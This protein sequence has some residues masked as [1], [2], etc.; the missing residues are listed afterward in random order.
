M[1]PTLLKMTRESFPMSRA[2]LT[3]RLK[4]GKGSGHWGHKGR[5]A[6]HERGGSVPGGGAGYNLGGYLHAIRRGV[7]QPARAALTQGILNAKPNADE[8]DIDMYIDVMALDEERFDYYTSKLGMENTAELK[9]QFFAERAEMDKAELRAKLRVEEQYTYMSEGGT[10]ADSMAYCGDGLWDAAKAGLVGNNLQDVEAELYKKYKI[11]V[12]YDIDVDPDIAHNELSMLANMLAADKRLGDV[13]T[14]C[15]RRI[16]YD[17]Q[18][19]GSTAAMS[20]TGDRI[21]VHPNRFASSYHWPTTWIH[22]IGHTLEYSLDD[23]G[24]IF[25]AGFGIGKTVSTYAR[26]NPQEDFAETFVSV[27]S[28]D[29]GPRSWEE[30]KHAFVDATIGG[31][32]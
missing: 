2:K 28:N 4:G 18:P 24:K 1:L 11:S 19:Y 16:V 32:Q 5:V 9:K 10:R 8:N 14:R 13:A 29:P 12:Q 25:D 26:I 6:T 7:P 3:L 30:G 17:A 21:L 20:S 31:V 15:T 23:V 22:E 27:I